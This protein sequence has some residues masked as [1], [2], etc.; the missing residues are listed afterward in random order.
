MF[1]LTEK[2][3]FSL[4]D[5]CCRVSPDEKRSGVLTE[6]GVSLLKEVGNVVMSSYMGALSI[7]TK[8][9]IIPSTPIFMSG[10]QWQILSTI[11]S[12]FQKEEF[13]LYTKAVLEEPST[14]IKSSIFLTL[15]PE[16][17]TFIQEAC[18]KSLDS[19]GTE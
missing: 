11:I 15:N 17:I 4:I 10:P 3:A 2:S 7:M 19:L 13:V 9:L 5:L 6:I 1:M 12:P 14:Q 16:G 8:T 18:K